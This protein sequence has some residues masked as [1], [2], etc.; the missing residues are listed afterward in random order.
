MLSIV[1][2]H[3]KSVLAMVDNQKTYIDHPSKAQGIINMNLI[4]KSDNQEK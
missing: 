4:R 2:T 1:D 3:Q